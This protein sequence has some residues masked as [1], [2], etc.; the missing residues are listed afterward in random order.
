MTNVI[1]NS[2][3]ISDNNSRGI[4]IANVEEKTTP[5]RNIT[6]TNNQISNNGSKK[7]GYGIV[8][9]SVRGLVI[10]GNNLNTDNKLQKVAIAVTEAEGTPGSAVITNNI[11]SKSHEHNILLPKKD[12]S[13]YIEDKNLI[14]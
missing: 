10:T 11:I 1:I 12:R 4:F 9:K 6:I 7:E 3:I 8:S 2:N 13:N 14:N 5:I